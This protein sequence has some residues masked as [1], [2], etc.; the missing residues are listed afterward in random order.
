MSGFETFVQNEL[1]NRQVLLVGTGN[2][3]TA[4]SNAGTYAPI[5]AYWLDSNDSFKRY[6]KYGEND[7][8][9]EIVP[10]ASDIGSGGGSSISNTL[11]AK[12]D[13]TATTFAA[14]SAIHTQVFTRGSLSV[15]MQSPS[16]VFIAMQE[17]N[18][19]ADGYYQEVNSKH[20]MVLP[21]DTYVKKIMFRSTGSG[22]ETVN[23][24]VH[25]NRDVTNIASQEY[26]YFD[27]APIET[28]TYTF[29]NNNQSQGY[30]FTSAASAS[31]GD[32]LGVS[33][34]ASGDVGLASLTIV[35]DFIKD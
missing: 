17:N 23:I 26:K 12:W 35:L 25:S 6:V 22:G 13:D 2:P 24:G 18:F 4:N 11:T 3:G 15:D 20:V 30:V 33:V 32:T 27:P 7:T 9:W 19:A 21:Y 8:D 28:Q 10:T 31:A 14:T 34:S 1:P 29:A 5:G 16:A